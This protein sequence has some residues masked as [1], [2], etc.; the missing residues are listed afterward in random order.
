MPEP[1]R[2]TGAIAEPANLPRRREDG[3]GK[4]QGEKKR[5]LPGIWNAKD[6]PGPAAWRKHDGKWLPLSTALF[7]SLL[8][9]F[10][11]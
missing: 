5:P 9:L 4:A 1:G 3:Q 7:Q 2:T 11:D 6:G 8:I 10:H